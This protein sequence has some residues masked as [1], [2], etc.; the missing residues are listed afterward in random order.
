M[1]ELKVRNDNPEG[2]NFVL[3][4]ALTPLITVNIYTQSENVAKGFETRE[5]LEKWLFGVMITNSRESV[6]SL[7][8]TGEHKYQMFIR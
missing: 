5:A 4:N 8:Q 3:E 2:K 1:F 7:E 6:I